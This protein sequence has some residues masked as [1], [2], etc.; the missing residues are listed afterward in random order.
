MPFNLIF[1]P[2]RI[3]LTVTSHSVTPTESRHLKKKKS[4]QR[5]KRERSRKKSH[6]RINLISF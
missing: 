6:K 1:K 3:F 5:A 4:K 2:R